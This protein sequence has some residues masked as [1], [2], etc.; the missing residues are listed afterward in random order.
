MIWII[1]KHLPVQTYESKS[2]DAR[3]ESGDEWEVEHL[4]SSNFLW[5]DTNSLTK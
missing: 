5:I 4:S 2:D 1:Q 3:S